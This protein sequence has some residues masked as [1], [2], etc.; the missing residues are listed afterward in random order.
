MSYRVH[1]YLHGRRQPRSYLFAELM[2]FD[3]DEV[4]R[5]EAP[6]AV[7]W[8]IPTFQF[9]GPDINAVRTY[10][11]QG[12]QHTVYMDGRHWVRVLAGEAGYVHGPSDPLMTSDF[13]SEVGKGGHLKTLGFSMPTQGQSSF[14]VVEGD[15]SDRFDTIS[16]NTR[17]EALSRFERM[18]LMSV[19]GVLY[20]AC[21]QPAHRLIFGRLAQDV[22][23]FVPFVDVEEGVCPGRPNARYLPFSA[24][25]EVAEVIG[26]LPYPIRPQIASPAIHIAESIS[27]DEDLRVL[28]DYHMQIFFT[29]A[30]GTL[31][32]PFAYVEKYFDLVTA[33][34]K[35]AYLAE[36]QELWSETAPRFGLPVERLHKALELLDSRTISMVTD[37][38]V[39]P[40]P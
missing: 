27:H 18:R 1:G 2:P 28:A 38:A 37:P 26:R 24:E 8:S 13:L 22:S 25:S 11:R 16:S 32:S 31:K 15:P 23:N 21:S 10:P 40:R 6:I 20:R 12:G 3:I 5:S 33:D 39:G 17:D 7:E 19:E 4:S 30:H 36:Y 35:A 9:D 14:T 34:D 29:A